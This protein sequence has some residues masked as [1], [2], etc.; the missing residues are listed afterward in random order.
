MTL[1]FPVRANPFPREVLC[2]NFLYI[3]PDGTLESSLNILALDKPSNFHHRVAA[4][5]KADEWNCIW[6]FVTNEDGPVSPYANNRIGGDFNYGRLREWAHKMQEM[7]DVGLRPVIFIQCDDGPTF[8]PALMDLNVRRIL[9]DCL[10]QYFDRF[11][12]VWCIG[13]EVSE[14]L[15]THL[16]HET[17]MYLQSKTG[18]PVVV[19]TQGRMAEIFNHPSIDAGLS[20]FSWHPKHKTWK[21][22]IGKRARNFVDFLRQRDGNQR[23]W[24]QV[25]AE[26]IH[27]LLACPGKHQVHGELNWDQD[28]VDHTLAVATIDTTYSRGVG[29]CCCPGLARFLGELPEG[30]N[31]VERGDI[32]YLSNTEIIVEANMTNGTVSMY[33]A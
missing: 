6:F 15:P 17:G 30:M 29:N 31:S 20:E 25:R 7:R 13:L 33:A 22:Y 16:I 19:H 18:N 21:R 5:A 11:D 3:E 4:M 14:Y 10:L 9:I 2:T 24:Q 26:A 28:R 1:S 32:V 12:P 8:N 27:N 23:T